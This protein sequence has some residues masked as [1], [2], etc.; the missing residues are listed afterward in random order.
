MGNVEAARYTAVLLEALQYAEQVRE[1]ECLSVQ[2]DQNLRKDMA[3]D[4]VDEIIGP[5]VFVGVARER[6]LRP[7][8]DR[9]DF[10]PQ[11]RDIVQG[12]VAPVHPE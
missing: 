9:V 6:M 1:P 5:V 7:V 8:M 2:R 4:R 10:L 11:V 3:D 12:A